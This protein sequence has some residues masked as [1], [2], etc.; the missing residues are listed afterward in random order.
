MTGN[1]PSYH[2]DM[3]GSAKATLKQQHLEA[4]QKGEGKRFVA[5]FAN[6]VDRLRHDPTDFGEPLYR[7]QALKLQIRQA[8]VDRL[9]VEYGVHADKPLVVI[10]RFKVLS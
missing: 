8:V 1:G 7:L 2:V 5:A 10:R 4:A 3:S 9:V 6:I